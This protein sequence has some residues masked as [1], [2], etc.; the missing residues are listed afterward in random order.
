[1]KNPLHFIVRRDPAGF[2]WN[3]RFIFISLG[4]LIT[5]SVTIKTWRLWNQDNSSLVTMDSRPARLSKASSETLNF[6]S[7]DLKPESEVSPTSVRPHAPK[8]SQAAPKPPLELSGRQVFLNSDTLAGKRE[9]RYLGRL[10]SG[11]DSRAQSYPAKF[12]VLK[13]LTS[14]PSLSKGDLVLANHRPLGKRLLFEMASLASSGGS[15]PLKGYILD[16]RSKLPGLEANYHGN[17]ISRGAAG[18]GLA[19]VA[20]SASYFRDKSLSREVTNPS[21]QNTLRGVLSSSATES[22][23][24]ASREYLRADLNETP[25]L[26][27]APGAY[28]E[29]V[30]SLEE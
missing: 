30:V 4:L 16:G 17:F 27:L 28:A 20:G 2:T 7:S 24:E 12:R 25:Y 3:M 8:L 18:M 9:E 23:S 15:S 6:R 26:T 13:S 1:M 11:V 14:N 29:L 22:A 10:E 19:A 21:Y 5:L